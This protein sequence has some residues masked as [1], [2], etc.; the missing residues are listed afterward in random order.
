MGK[1]SNEKRNLQKN[2]II[3]II[4]TAVVCGIMLAM[5]L[6][7]NYLNSNKTG[8]EA[9]H[10]SKISNG[11]QAQTGQEPAGGSAMQLL[12]FQRLL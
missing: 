5:Y 8:T 11:R 4:L 10:S 2:I 12:G 7:T 1:R 6:L 9:R 3:G